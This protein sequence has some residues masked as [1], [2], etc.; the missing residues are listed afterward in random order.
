MVASRIVA[1]AL[2]ALMTGCSV[3]GGKAAEE[4]PFE[5]LVSEPPHEIRRYGPIVVAQTT[6][7]AP[8]DTAVR[9]G[10]GRLFDYISG[11]NEPPAGGSGAEIAMTA[12]VL[13]ER[14]AEIAMTAPVL[15][16]GAD[17]SGPVTIAFVL[18]EGYDLASAPRPTDPLVEL[19]E[20][21]ARRV[22]VARFSGSL[23]EAGIAEARAG[24]EVWLAARGDRPASGSGGWQA[25]GYNPPWTLPWLRRNEVIVTLSE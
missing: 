5:T 9:T 7:D 17:G 3:F 20:I 25:A 2:G 1:L 8:Y 10:F 22:G 18:P 21:P 12:P 24:L 16:A 19:A 23:D 4:P 15:T 6:V 14:E 11:A 13:T